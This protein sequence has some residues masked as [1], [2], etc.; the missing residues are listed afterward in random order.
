MNTS[1]LR[2]I[3]EKDSSCQEAL[4]TI[5]E[6]VDRGWYAGGGKTGTHWLFVDR[7]GTILEVSHSACDLT[8]AYHEEKVYFS[9]RE[10]SA[11]AR[12]LRDAAEPIGF[13]TFHRVSRD[14]S[15]CFDSSISGMTVE[16]DREYPQY[17]TCAWIS[18]PAKSLSLP[19]FMGQKRTPQC[20]LDGEADTLGRQSTASREVWERAEEEAHAAKEAV[21]E[22]AAALFEEQKYEQAQVLLSEWGETHTEKCL[23]FIGSTTEPAEGVPPIAGSGGV[24]NYSDGDSER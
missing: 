21:K 11:A 19:L 6:F 24:E 17:L 10:E 7:Q 8:F 13:S 14:P 18:L 1:I 15:V 9:A 20:L 2:L 3:A 23:A 16:I 4:R 22:E 12:T 5:Q